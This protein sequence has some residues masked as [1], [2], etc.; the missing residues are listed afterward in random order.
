[1]H[2]LPAAPTLIGIFAV[3]LLA[4]FHCAGMCGGFAMALGAS[5]RRHP[6]GAFGVQ[7]LYTLGRLS[8]YML[9]GA[10]AGALGGLLSAS[11]AFAYGSAALAILAGVA[12]ATLGLHQLGLLPDLAARA[13]PARWH[14]AVQDGLAWAM[15]LDDPAVPYA[16]GLLNGLLPCGLVAGWLALAAASGSALTGALVLAT[17]GLGTVPVMLAA[18]LLPSG[19]PLRWRQR[20]VR[21]SG[22]F[23]MVFAVL[24][25]SRAAW[26]FHAPTHANSSATVDPTA[27]PVCLPGA[28]LFVAPGS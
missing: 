3:A 2:P 10:L 12:M 17:A 18:G 28:F 16:L 26:A 15:R 11:G 23:L 20:L 5:A 19:L 1:M 8:M 25:A 14:R 9:L 21:T 4:S 7:G 27:A 13:A 24:S 6:A 22:V